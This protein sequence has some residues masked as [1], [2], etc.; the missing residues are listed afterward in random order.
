M[1][2]IKKGTYR[3][4]DELL[5][6]D[7]A[8]SADIP[9]TISIW[10]DNIPTVLKFDRMIFAIMWAL[11]ARLVS[12]DP[13]MDL[14][15][16]GNS[17]YLYSEDA[18][19]LGWQYEGL[20]LDLQ[21]ITVTE[22]TEVSDTFYHRFSVNTE[23]QG[24]YIEKASWYKRVADAIRAKKGTSELISR[25]D[26]AAE[27]EGISG[28][29]SECS[30]D[31]VIE[32]DE[33]PAEGVEGAVYKVKETKLTDIMMTMGDSAP[34]SMLD[35]FEALG[36]ERPKI[37]NVDS[38]DEVTE[39]LPNS[40][41]LYYVK[42]ENMLYTY[43][44]DDEGNNG[45]WTAAPEGTDDDGTMFYV[46][47]TD[48]LYYVWGSDEFSDVILVGDGVAASF[49]VM[50]RSNGMTYSFNT[51]P[52]KTTE[53]I[54]VSDM[55]N[56]IFHWY[57]IEDE[58]DI[59]IFGDLD[60]TGANDWVSA[61][62]VF[63]VTYKGVVADISEA[64]EDGY[65]AVGIGAPYWKKYFIPMGKMSAAANGTYD[66]S[67]VSKFN[68]AIPEYTGSVSI[69]TEDD[70]SGDDTASNTLKGYWR[71]N[72]VIDFSGFTG[73]IT[74]HF[75]YNIQEIK[76]GIWI[77]ADIIFNA[78]D[79]SISLSED[80]DTGGSNES[81]IYTAANG[82]SGRRKFLLRLAT[83]VS[84]DFYQIFTAN[85]K[86]ISDTV[87]MIACGDE[88][89]TVLSD[90]QQATVECADK[91]LN[92]DIVIDPVNVPTTS[93]QATPT[94]DVSSDGLI[95]ATAGDK[96]AT[97]QLTTEEGTW[98]TPGRSSVIAV[99][100]GRY[101]TG[102]VVV[103]GSTNLV[104]SNIKKGVDIFGVVG[105]LESLDDV[106][107]ALEDGEYYDYPFI[108]VKSGNTASYAPDNNLGSGYF[109]NAS[110]TNVVGSSCATLEFD[111]SENMLVATGESK[112]LCVARFSF[113]SEAD[114]DGEGNPGGFEEQ[115]IVILVC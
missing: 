60:G 88:I 17:Y 40:F 5:F 84:S 106:A 11:M 68:V 44:T 62:V 69:T 93:E 31:H 20:G 19:V 110:I 47:S 63:G 4:N 18:D 66:V 91:Y 9:F 104:A 7:A 43:Q 3:L 49:A 67:E 42:S 35:F 37:F 102:D 45:A 30:G 8:D 34:F 75:D 48:D 77:G 61:S 58:N 59:F 27:I 92:G 12:V 97:H 76:N 94:I 56:N 2:I 89:I 80:G 64:T 82:W 55:D 105:T 41:G 79:Q 113:Y 74:Q 73:T 1:A 25:D 54:S 65:Y 22:D 86:N 112:G 95:T 53:D 36:V 96:S 50:A 6:G 21:T 108:T 57:Y 16:A 98:I 14:F 28:G 70:S 10:N 111:S 71:L 33:L 32:V 13:A 103:E 115:L 99:K 26:F 85:A 114:S 15:V 100:S 38:L 72:D 90:G 101:T 24:A 46:L 81:K 107:A 83:T 39:P 109:G 52:T 87:T 78:D 23:L 29:S 51:I